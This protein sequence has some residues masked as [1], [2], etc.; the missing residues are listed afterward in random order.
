[1]KDSGIKIKESRGG[2]PILW[3]FVTV[4]IAILVAGIAIGAAYFVSFI[5]YAPVIAEVTGVEEGSDDQNAVIAD[6]TFD[7][8]EYS[9]VV[10]VGADEDAQTGDKISALCKKS[11]PSVARAEL[12][13]A[14]L[15][16]PFMLMGFGVLFGGIALAPLV[17]HMRKNKRVSFARQR[18][19]P[20]ECVVTEV[21][22]D[23]SFCVNGKAVNNL[24]ACRPSDGY[25]SDGTSGVR[26]VSAPFSRKYDVAVGSKVTVYVLPEDPSVYWVDLNSATAPARDAAAPA[27]PE[28]Y[29]RDP[30]ADALKKAAGS[31]DGIVGGKATGEKDGEN[32][33]KSS[34]SGENS[35]STGEKCGA[36][37]A[38]GGKAT[39]EK[40][41]ENAIKSSASGEKCASAGEKC[42]AENSAS[43]NG[44]GAKDTDKGESASGNGEKR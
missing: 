37:N 43:G 33:I 9:G 21:Y 18:G 28:G 13:F 44:I 34:A 22:S 35:A 19:T 36:E 40:D 8:E 32:A 20:V 16:L 38:V 14:P 42:G 10:I 4:G 1:M 25:M 17:G 12:F 41:G 30:L 11:D 6:Y 26:Y 24:A 23:T 31:A 7:G 29:S 15:P 5:S 27:F 39:G 3:V 2:Y